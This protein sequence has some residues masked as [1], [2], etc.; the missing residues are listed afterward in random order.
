M[1]CH[2]SSRIATTMALLTRFARKARMPGFPTPTSSSPTPC[3]NGSMPPPANVLWGGVLL[4]LNPY[5]VSPSSTFCGSCCSCGLMAGLVLT[6]PSTVPRINAAMITKLATTCA[7]S[8]SATPA[9]RHAPTAGWLHI[10]VLRLAMLGWLSLSDMSGDIILNNSTNFPKA[11]PCKAFVSPSAANSVPLRRSAVHSGDSVLLEASTTSSGDV[12]FSK[13][14]Y[15]PSCLPVSY[16]TFLHRNLKRFT[17]GGSGIADLEPIIMPHQPCFCRALCDKRLPGGFPCQQVGSMFCCD[18]LHWS[19]FLMWWSE[20][21]LR[22]HSQSP[23]VFWLLSNWPIPQSKARCVVEVLQHLMGYSDHHFWSP[24]NHPAHQTCP[25]GQMCSPHKVWACFMLSSSWFSS[26]FLPS[27]L[28]TGCA[29]TPCTWCVSRIP[30][31]SFLLQQKTSIF[32]SHHLKA[33]KPHC[34]V[35]GDVLFP[36]ALPSLLDCRK[37]TRQFFSFHGD[38]EII[39][40]N[41]GPTCGCALFFFCFFWCLADLP[42]VLFWC[43]F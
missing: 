2:I 20:W 12:W 42:Q 36:W 11:W 28:G 32:H 23:P 21:C 29:S 6:F 3:P 35:C 5:G 16:Q 34:L 40:I 33:A 9:T 4:R 43:P 31:I 27:I 22:Q 26:S 25:V 19:I 38:Q 8:I 7:C 37:R 39:N 41:S 24:V 15:R 18:S 13:G 1:V 30:H 17:Q 10:P 14:Q